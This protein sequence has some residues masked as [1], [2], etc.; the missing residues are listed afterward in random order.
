MQLNKNHDLKKDLKSDNYHDKYN[1][2][3]KIYTSSLFLPEVI[4][5]K[6]QKTSELN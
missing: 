2:N 3:K 6:N 1:I 5:I 4:I